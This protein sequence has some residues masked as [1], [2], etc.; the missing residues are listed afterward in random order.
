MVNKIKFPGGWGELEAKKLIP[1]TIIYKICE[2]NS[3]F[4]MK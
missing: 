4:H 2:T 3:S 1:E